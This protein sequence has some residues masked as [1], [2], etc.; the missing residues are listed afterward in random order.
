MGSF[1][2]VT[3]YQQEIQHCVLV[4]PYLIIAGY[5]KCYL[6]VMELHRAN[7]IEPVHYL[8]KTKQNRT[9]S[10]EQQSATQT[11]PAA[12]NPTSAASTVSSPPAGPTAS[13][14]HTHTHTHS[15]HIF[16]SSSS[17]TNPLSQRSCPAPCHKTLSHSARTLSLFS[18]SNSQTRTP[19]YPHLTPLITRSFSSQFSCFAAF[20]M[21][22]RYLSTFMV[23]KYI[24]SLVVFEIGDLQAIGIPNLGWLERSIDD[25]YFDTDF[26]F[27]G[28]RTERH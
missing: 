3:K 7:G 9:K 13:P 22:P 15:Q 2:R 14:S 23:Y 24:P 27:F 20:D 16:C 4:L 8:L 18:Y 6:Q 28:L 1:I 5:G 12:P 10:F 21:K 19:S 17:H 25:I 26:G 11:H